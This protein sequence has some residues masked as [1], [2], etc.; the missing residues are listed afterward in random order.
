MKTSGGRVVIEAHP[1]NSG[2]DHF[3]GRLYQKSM[4]MTIYVLL[5]GLLAQLL[6]TAVGVIY[7]A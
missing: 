3:P 7:P 2:R 5:T 4:I 1:G 6:D